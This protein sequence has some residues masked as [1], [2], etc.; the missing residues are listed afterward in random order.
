MSTLITVHEIPDENICV[1]FITILDHIAECL[2]LDCTVLFV[3]IRKLASEQNELKEKMS[4]IFKITPVI[5]LFVSIDPAKSEKEFNDTIALRRFNP[6][7][8]NTRVQ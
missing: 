2:S 1:P 8:E 6:T 3:D 5:L 4:I 7:K